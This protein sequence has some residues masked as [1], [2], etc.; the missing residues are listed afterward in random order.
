VG[1]YFD[2][3]DPKVLKAVHAAA[4]VFVRLGARVTEVDMSFLADAAHANAQMTRADAAAFHH[5]RMEAHPD[6]FGEDV[7]ARLQAGAACTSTEYARVRRVQSEMVR[8][9][10]LFFA[11]YDILLTPTTPITAPP[12][13]GTDAVQA[14]RQLTRFTAP[15]NLTGLPALSVPCGR[16]DGLPVGL[17]IVSRAWDETKVLQAGRAYE[18]AVLLDLRPAILEKS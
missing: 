4:K 12:I 5:E 11:N 15:F 10:E 1:E 14:A 16:V 9:M 13:D 17:Q 2:N 6:W 3:D 8:R 18:R 7:L